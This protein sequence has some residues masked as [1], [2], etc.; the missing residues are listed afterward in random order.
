MD[1]IGLLNTIVSTLK[2][3]HQSAENAAQEA[4][5]VA[6][7]EENIAENKYD[8]M[9]LE[10]SYLAHG[11]KKRQAECEADLICIKALQPII[12]N[13]ETAITIGA[14]ILLENIETETQQWLF[15]SPAAG[16]VQLQYTG[17]TIT[18]ITPSSP[19][20]QALIERHQGDDFELS[21]QGKKVAFEVLS[22][23]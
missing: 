10:A 8:T 21:I 4:H 1:K 12:F 9:G 5:H 16:G 18:L 6:T 20:G 22:V 14:V 3:L 13:A 23:L 19:L 11:Q 15:L 2:R 17:K 7:H